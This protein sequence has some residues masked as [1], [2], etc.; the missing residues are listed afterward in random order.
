MGGE[1]KKNHTVKKFPYFQMG[2]GGKLG[3]RFKKYMKGR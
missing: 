3:F 2:R 1:I